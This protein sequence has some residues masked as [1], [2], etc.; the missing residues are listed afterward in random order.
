MKE[1]KRHLPD[2]CLQTLL[3]QTDLNGS[4]C[5]WSFQPT[6]WL[7]NATVFAESSEYIHFHRDVCSSNV[8]RH[9]S[10]RCR[11]LF[12][13]LIYFLSKNE[14]SVLLYY[15]YILIIEAV[16]FHVCHSCFIIAFNVNIFMVLKEC[17]E[18]DKKLRKE[19]QEKDTLEDQLEQIQKE[20]PSTV[21]LME[22]RLNMVHEELSD[23]RNSNLQL[24]MEK[25][26]LHSEI[27]RL[28]ERYCRFKIIF[29]QLAWSQLVYLS[30]NS[31]S[32]NCVVNHRQAFS[33]HLLF[34]LLF[35]VVYHLEVLIVFQE[36][37]KASELW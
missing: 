8:Y 26:S 33:D 32:H 2:S 12:F 1:R 22:K 20:A 10:G 15:K 35:S 3:E 34:S 16:F 11:S 25:E 30:K 18:R 4:G 29:A 31:Y 37:E 19:A 17:N 27:G 7:M 9:E 24:V 13:I 28:Q 36:F 21:C 5:I 23:A 14:V 6:L